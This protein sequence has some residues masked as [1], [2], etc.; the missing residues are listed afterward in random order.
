MEAKSLTGDFPIFQR[1]WAFQPHE[2]RFSSI[3]SM[4]NPKFK[5][6]HLDESEGNRTVLRMVLQSA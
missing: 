3:V 1:A 5:G 6:T 4:N 2:R